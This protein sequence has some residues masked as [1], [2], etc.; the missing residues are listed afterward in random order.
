MIK[1]NLTKI[2]NY[3][4]K[5]LA[6]DKQYFPIFLTVIGLYSLIGCIFVYFGTTYLPSFTGIICL[7]FMAGSF[8]LAY[9]MR[10]AHNFAYARVNKSHDHE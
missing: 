3:I 4:I 1:Y 9:L 2:E 10:V 5:A 8:L 6:N 7:L